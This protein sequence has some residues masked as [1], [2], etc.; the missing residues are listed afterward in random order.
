MDRKIFLCILL[1]NKISLLSARA[2]LGVR[3]LSYSHDAAV[4]I[5]TVI[6]FR[7]RVEKSTFERSLCFPM[8]STTRA[9]STGSCTNPFSSENFTA[10]SVYCSLCRLYISDRILSIHSYADSKLSV[11]RF[12]RVFRNLIKLGLFI[13]LSSILYFNIIFI[14]F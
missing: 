9:Q 14:T 3:M 8:C 1:S 13:I 2:R 5:A 11:V 12:S 4:D 10:Y 7:P 6:P